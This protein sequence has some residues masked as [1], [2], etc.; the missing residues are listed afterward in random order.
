MIG[1][2]DNDKDEVLDDELLNIDLLKRRELTQIQY[3]SSHKQIMVPNMG[4]ISKVFSEHLIIVRDLKL[5]LEE[6]KQAYISQQ[7][8][9]RSWEK[10]EQI[11]TLLRNACTFLDMPSENYLQQFKQVELDGTLVNTQT[12]GEYNKLKEETQ[13]KK[14]DLKVQ[15]KKK[16]SKKDV[17]DIE[18]MKINEV[19]SNDEESSNMSD[20]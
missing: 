10:T 20:P 7:D 18:Q 6:L 8:Q 15:I 1:E 17:V 4:S 3:A 5:K 12:L 13:R 11:I 16:Q 14:K 19:D 2:P 9:K